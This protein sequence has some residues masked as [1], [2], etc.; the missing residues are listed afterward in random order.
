VKTCQV[1]KFWYYASNLQD[2]LS[3]CTFICHSHACFLWPDFTE[4]FSELWH[5][6][7]EDDSC[8][9]SALLNVMMS[10]CFC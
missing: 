3:P 1:F 8:G 4:P 2:S 7:E 6:Q 10:C 5:L 9:S